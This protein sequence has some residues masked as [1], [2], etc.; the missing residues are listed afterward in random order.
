MPEL[1]TPLEDDAPERHGP[2]E[3]V[4]EHLAL[5]RMIASSL[6]RQRSFDGVPFE[7][8]VQFGVEGLL[9][10][11]RRFKPHLGI[12]FET[13]AQHRIRGAIISGLEK[14]TEVNQQVASMRRQNQERLASISE[15]VDDSTADLDDCLQRLVSASIGL[16]ISFM[17][18]DSGMY[19]DGERSCWRDGANNLAYKQLQGRLTRA[20]DDLNDKER[21]VLEW[22]YFEHEPFDVAAQHLGLSKG[23]VSQ[24]HRSALNK[25]RMALASNQLG[26]L[27]A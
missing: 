21:A 12:R 20:L 4:N 3:L 11:G 13:Y 6:Y 18:E 23:R 8:Y 24:L 10:A 22:H 7:E 17:L 19:V 27:I 2:S 25:L 15:D 1:C 26:D 14:S 5:V 16:A 9:Q